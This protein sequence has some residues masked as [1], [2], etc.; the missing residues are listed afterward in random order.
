MLA[1]VITIAVLVAGLA[2]YALHRMRKP[3][4]FT[5]KVGPPKFPLIHIEV[6]SDDP[7]GEVPPGDRLPEASSIP[8][9]S[10]AGRQG[11]HIR[12]HVRG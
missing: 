7:R 3:S 2:A 1:V 8:R 6:E 5:L 10:P 4:R 9:W 11:R 12:R